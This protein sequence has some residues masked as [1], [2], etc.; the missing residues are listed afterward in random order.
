MRKRG[1]SKSL[2]DLEANVFLESL[3]WTDLS[4]LMDTGIDKNFSLCVLGR[5]VGMKFKS[6]TFKDSL[7]KACVF[8]DVTSVNTYFKNCTFIDTLFDNT[9]RCAT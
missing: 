9:G 2:E 7:F 3:W 4:T 5:F 1:E 8:E 6:V